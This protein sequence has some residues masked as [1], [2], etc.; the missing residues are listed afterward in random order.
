EKV[1]VTARHHTFFEMLGNFSFGDYFKR[2]AIAFAW[3]LLVDRFELSPSRLAVTI[4][5]GDSEVPRDAEA[6][7]LWTEIVATERIHELGRADNFWSMGDTGP[8]GPCSEIHYFQGDHLPCTETRCKGVACECDRWLEIWNLVFMQ[9][10]RDD[11]GALRPLPAPSV[12]TGMGLERI[13]AVVQGVESNYDTD[14][15]APIL[16]AIEERVG[17]RYRGSSSVED[18]AFRVIADH[19]RSATFL[20]ADGV[21]PSND[22]RGYVLRK[23][24]R[25]AMRHGKKL[26]LDEP[27]LFE[28]TTRVIEEMREP[29]PDLLLSRELVGRV[30]RS[31]EERFRTTLSTG[32]SVLEEKLRLPEVTEKRVLPGSHAF[33][34]YDTFGVPFD[35]LTDIAS[36]HGIEVDEAG[37]DEAMEVQRQRARESWKKGS[38]ASDRTHYGE[39]RARGESRFQGYSATKIPES[40]VVALAKDGLEVRELVEGDEGEVFLDVT[41]FYPEGG[42]QV[43]DQGV[44]AGPDGAADVLDTQSP[45]SGLISHRVRLSKGSIGV[46]QRVVATVNETVREGAKRHH[47]ITHMLHAAL[48]ETLGPHVKQKGSLVAPNRLRFDF[49]HFAPLSPSE[50]QQIEGRVNEKIQEDLAVES[51]VL[52]IDDAL[53]RGAIAFFGEKY[54]DRVRV[55]EIPDFS[56]ELCGGTHLSR[57]GEAGF[58]VITSESSISSGVRRI[59]ALTGRAALEFARSNRALVTELSRSLRARPDELLSTVDKL[60]DEL[61]RKER[62]NE[63]LKKRLVLGTRARGEESTMAIGDVLVWTPPPVQNLDKKQHRQLVDAFKEKNRERTW[64]VISTAVNEEKVSLIVEVSEGLASQIRAD[65]LVKELAPIIEG[66][67]GGKAER[68]EAG[69]RFPDRIPE[70]YERGRDAIRLALEGQRV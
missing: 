60:K 24:L 57:T 9:F 15:F 62:E 10:N 2:D 69:G 30:V 28:L 3:E 4:F 55:I 42:G 1:G 47:T 23:I 27:F 25:R 52:P 8:C 7:E 18:V 5:E 36:E 56:I 16:R 12:D 48:R 54:G 19:A 53:A 70:L 29:Y 43:G 39:I 20:I 50:I 34:L 45:V 11:N 67:G 31:E 22:G 61:K 46:D 58:F 51:S 63:E 66:R 41:P 68:A 17:K 44:L 26:G 13:T 38:P 32:I 59:E 49:S 64:A 65:Q 33:E 14:I 21:M 37:F 40:R 6:Y 35:L